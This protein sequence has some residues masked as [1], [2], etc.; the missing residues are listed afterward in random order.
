MSRVRVD[1]AAAVTRDAE[2][3]ARR[4]IPSRG[5]RVERTPPPPPLLQPLLPRRESDSA[6]DP[7]GCSPG[8]CTGSG[9]SD[10]VRCEPCHSSSNSS[11]PT[12]LLLRMVQRAQWSPI[13]G[14]PGYTM[15]CRS[16]GLGSRYSVGPGPAATDD[17]T[18]FTALSAQEQELILKVTPPHAA[19]RFRI[20]TDTLFT[21]DASCIAQVN[22]PVHI[23]R[24]RSALRFLQT[25]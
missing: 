13:L 19:G 12:G 23:V 7:A 9:G 2:T 18:T 4:V 8:L 6:G 21:V 11:S 16:Q 24:K 10:D 14:G 22:S 3:H 15:Y 5:A 20:Q 1:A 25:T 17:R